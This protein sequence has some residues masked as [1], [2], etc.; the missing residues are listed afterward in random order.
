MSEVG[1]RAEAFDLRAVEEIVAA[2][3]APAAAE[4]DRAGAFPR[5]ALEAFGRAGLL[6]LVSSREVGGLGESHR[7]ASQVVERVATA[8]ASTAMVLCMHYSGAAVVEAHGPREVREVIA[9]GEHVTTLAFSEQGSRSH[10][11]APVGTAATADGG[12]RLDAHKSWVTSAGEADSYVWSS[13]PLEAEGNST[14][15]LVP[16]G[17]GGLS[18]PKPFD[19]LGLRGNSSSPVTAEG[20][21]VPRENML[22]ADGGGFDVMMGV[23]LP[24]FQLMSAGFSVGTM[25]AATRK[26]AAH[27]AGTQF[28]HLGSAL[29]D[30]PTVRAYLARMRVRTDM[31]RALLE[32]SLTALETGREDAM[33]RVLEVKAA[34]G[35][36]STEVTDLAMRVCGG[37]AFRREV[38]VERHFRDARAATVMAPT[39][40]VLYDF[41]GKAVCGLPLFG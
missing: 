3:V 41:I 30:L 21:V 34:A 10:F 1:P 20:V 39:T 12:V 22:G 14:I 37:A 32:D 33:L 9:R 4:V 35:E 13:R 26:A 19:G 28:E 7:A 27:V 2:T 18:I 17:A 6:G 25:E 11:W 36:A 31:C 24:Y 8:C 40:D 15:W 38:G 16:A 5:A 29:A 23:V